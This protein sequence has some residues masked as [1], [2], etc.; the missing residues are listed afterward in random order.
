MSIKDLAVFETAIA[1]FCNVPSATITECI[2]AV[3][4]GFGQLWRVE[5]T[6]S[7]CKLV[8]KYICEPTEQNHPRGWNNDFATQ[9][10]LTSYANERRWY[11]HYS[12][13]LPATCILPKFKGLITLPDN[14]HL[15]LMED[16]SANGFYPK[17]SATPRDIKGAIRWLASLHQF[18]LNRQFD[19]LWQQGNY[20]HLATRPVEFD[21]M[22]SSPLK[23]AAQALDHKL[24]NA[25]YRCLI[26]GDAKLANFCFNKTATAAAVDF[27]YIGAGIGA[28]DLVYFLG[29]CISEYELELYYDD[30]VNYY[31]NKLSEGLEPALSSQLEAEWRSLLPFV[32]ADFQRFVEGWCPGHHK[33]TDFSQYQTSVALSQL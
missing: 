3:W 26:H 20:W 8:V 4:S 19:D 18:S 11:Q 28:Q 6:G 22:P 21:A 16:L 10:K 7:K 12:D 1:N 17:A 29:S 14:A 5:L 31:F 9:R 32:W 30:W 33:D 25:Q 13:A 15:L 24:Q 27:Q 23:S 2:Q